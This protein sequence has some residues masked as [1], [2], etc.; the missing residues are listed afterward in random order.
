[1]QFKT[2]SIALDTWLMVVSTTFMLMGGVALVTNSLHLS[3]PILLATDT[4]LASLFTGIGLL[5]VWL[6]QPGL[7]VIAGIA[8][9]GLGIDTLVEGGLGESPGTTTGWLQAGVTLG[10]LEASLMLAVAPCLLLG[11]RRPWL[12]KLW[13]IAGM[14]LLG[15]SALA[16]WTLFGGSLKGWPAGAAYSEVL[17]L[18][19]L[20]L[21][22]AMLV[23]GY[24]PVHGRLYIGPRTLCACLLGVAISSASWYLLNWQQLVRETGRAEL[25]FE[26]A[27]LD[28]ERA[29]S[30]RLQSLRRMAERLNASSHGSGGRVARYDQVSYLRD[31]SSLSAFGVITREGRWQWLRGGDAEARRWLRQQA[32]RPLVEEWDASD[33][34]QPIMLLPDVDH[35]RQALVVVG[36]P[37]HD[38][39]LVASI[40][41]GR[42]LE[43]ELH[44]S[45][46]TFQ[47]ALLH[48]GET[49][50][51]VAAPGVTPRGLTET[52]R[53][54][55]RSIGLPGGVRLRLDI[56][57][58]MPS[59]W[60]MALGVPAFVGLGGLV[61]SFLL[62][63]SL[64]LARLNADRSRELDH[65]RQHLVRQQAIQAMIAEE[66]PL[67]A[68]LE[69][70]CEMLEEQ[71]PQRL[72]SIMLANQA[73]TRLEL[74]AG[75]RLPE[76][77][78][79]AIRSV[80]IAEGVGACGSAAHTGRLVVCDDLPGDPAWRGY[81]ALAREHSLLACWSYPVLSRDN[82]VLGTFAV[83][84]REHARPTEHE[85]GLVRQAV[86][87]VALA[88]ERDHDRRSLR[89]SEQRY[90]SLFS[91]N[92]DAVF[93][94]DMQGYFIS[95]NASCEEVTGYRLDEIR[96]AHYSRFVQPQEMSRIQSHFDQVL[97]GEAQRYQ[98]EVVGRSGE[99]RQLDLT[100]LPI[101]V[102]GSIR[103][104]FGIAKD[105][106][107]RRRSEMRLRI[108]EQGVEVSVNGLVIVDALKPDMPMTYVNRAFEA[109]S[110]YCR[111]EV[112]GRNCRFLQGPD[113][114]PGAL[115]ELRDRLA[116]QQEAHVTLCNY[117][118]DGGTFWNELYVSPIRDQDGQVT[119][120]VGIQH[121][122]SERMAYEGQLA[123][124]AR[125][126]VLTGL[127]NR[128]VLED[129]LPRD[130]A[131]ANRE[132]KW[133]CVLF[134]DLDGFK[135]INDSLGHAIG[136]QLLQKLARRL[137]EMVRR[138]DTLVR[139]GGDEFVLLLND[140]GD[141]QR[142]MEVAERLL[143]L[144]ARPYRIE[145]H[146]LHLTASIGIAVNVDR[147]TRPME[148]IQQAD[149]AMYRA[150]QQGRNTYQW[151]TPEITKRVSERVALR[152]EL[153]EAID[154][155]SFELHYQPLFDR[156][157]EVVGLEALLRWSHPERGDISPATF[158]PIAEQTGQIIPISRWVL[159]RACRDMEALR[160]Q[161]MSSLG[162]S[163]NISPLQFQRDNFL[164]ILAD[165]LSLTGLPAEWLTLEL[166]EG[167]LM[168]E[169]DSA[170][171]ALDALR[172]M[173]VQVAID[174][175]GTGFSSLS[176]LKNLP[177][178]TVKIDR[179]FIREIDRNADDASLAQGIT[180]MA[181]HLGLRVVAEGVE[182]DSQYQLV[183]SHG[184]DL[185]QGF[186]LA[187]PMS[188]ERLQQFL[189]KRRG[190]AG[191]SLGTGA[192]FTGSPL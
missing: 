125:H 98:L 96:G 119:H 74:A 169:T 5:G 45:L 20:L 4:A 124:H 126:D 150:K 145:G 58:A 9:A 54:L 97:K 23:A 143:D 46:S 88:I 148:L 52:P 142:A 120:Y 127:A 81:Q 180:S 14:L 116:S 140:P 178:D 103:G 19:T 32:G 31:L 44:V 33:F 26:T 157:G 164:A 151:F 137:T 84:S 165:T 39:R 36:I 79:A 188:F 132:G 69:A 41:L 104:V 22:A 118:K 43:S 99:A 115:Q 136:D 76:A 61:L 107:Q 60:P 138:E 166:T 35:P 100:N 72:C 2:A 134:I 101:I 53:M 94:L 30:S 102:D 21:G 77:Y 27:R 155:D 129:R 1:M 17:A 86:D 90:R 131:L 156:D 179:S 38:Y 161:G 152:S 83:Y 113:T 187:R 85:L 123:Y 176:Y 139:F 160:R 89:E 80:P 106:T 93:S 191:V 25:I 29:V 182:T 117:R 173:G 144:V 192:P 184:C 82:R 3:G 133:L 170:I 162:V 189:Q 65:S 10:A 181:H 135:P 67:D 62:T 42:L 37:R 111:E 108:L 168:S 95:A 70:V 185:F 11:M 56:H 159:T 114:D 15:I 92:P 55:S 190:S 171:E 174:D 34:S 64:G 112:L 87:I 110:G 122:V 154:T 13:R 105:I 47:V 18:F 12:R 175:F 8:M 128:V 24:R 40:H 172:S 66:A 68:P 177:V 109:M 146:E 91:Y 49:L 28:T 50:L 78:R 57:S 75:R 6:R 141:E 167:I 59:L 71:L 63:L 183:R 7:R 16:L 186:L 158:I 51:R 130:L 147:H 153:Q 121:D 48:G 163:V 149:M 73:G